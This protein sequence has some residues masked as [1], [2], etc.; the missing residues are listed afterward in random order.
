MTR[1]YL[2]AAL[3]A[4]VAASAA[5]SNDNNSPSPSPSSNAQLRVV[6]ASPDAPNV[7]V[8][9]DGAKVLTNVPYLASSGYLAVPAGAHNVKVNATGTATTVIDVTPTLV[10]GSYYTAM[11]TDLVAGITPLLLADTNSAP[12]AGKVKVRLV[13]AAPGAGVVDIY[14]TA[15]GADLAA[16]TPTLT[17]IPFQAVS[18]YLEVPAGDYQVRITPAGTKTVAID[19]GTLTLTAGQ[20]RTGVAVENV[21]GGAPFGAIVLSDN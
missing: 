12:S 20:I 14:V 6:H 4:L 3:A 15:P 16:A 1:T 13:H 10:A 11:A 2:A 19:S 5:C 7:D 18:G 8:Y 9:L 21:G 17:N